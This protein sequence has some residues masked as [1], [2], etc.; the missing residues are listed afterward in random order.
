[1]ENME[2]DDR[3]ELW[4]K[5]D[6][7]WTLLQN[8]EISD[9]ENLEKTDVGIP[10]NSTGLF[11]IHLRLF[12]SSRTDSIDFYADPNPLDLVPA[13]QL[14][15]AIQGEPLHEGDSLTLSALVHNRGDRTVS[16]LLELVSGGVES[17]GSPVVIKPGSSK[18]LETSINVANT[19]SITVYWAVIGDGIG[20]SHLLS[21]S[22]EVTV[23]PTQTLEITSVIHDAELDSLEVSV[24]LSE[25]RDRELRIS[26]TPS[27]SGGFNSQSPQVIASMM[28]GLQSFSLPVPGDYSGEMEVYAEPIGWSGEKASEKIILEPLFSDANLIGEFTPHGT[29]SPFQ[30][31]SYTIRNTGSSILNN[32]I[33]EAIWVVDGRVISTKQIPEI[34][35]SDEYSSKI[36]FSQSLGGTPGEIQLVYKSNLGTHITT[37]QYVPESDDNGGF[38]FPFQLQAAI[39]GSVMGV[40]VLLLTILVMR[41]FNTQVTTTNFGG[42]GTKN[43]KDLTTKCSNCGLQLYHSKFEQNVRCPACSTMNTPGRRKRTDPLNSKKISTVQET[44]MTASSSNDIISCPQCSQALKVPMS[45]RPVMAR[46]PACKCTFE[47]TVEESA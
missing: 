8:G 42:E 7:I 43:P 33:I 34:Y 6:G 30:E 32:G 29:D 10:I 5:H 14:G 4:M 16:P 1:Q 17:K 23:L 35:P 11:E 37:V 13:G 36:S 3:W 45:R 24:L 9:G 46:C 38:E 28:P 25:G 40:V 26:A 15:V 19:G 47:A 27:I 31:I 39:I 20:V 12:P 2:D 18:E 22:I 41:T 44:K 21:D